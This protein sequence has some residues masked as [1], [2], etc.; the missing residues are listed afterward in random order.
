[1]MLTRH[2]SKSR[3]TKVQEWQRKGKAPFLPFVEPVGVQDEERTCV[4]NAATTS[5]LFNAVENLL[6]KVDHLKYMEFFGCREVQ[7]YQ[8]LMCTAAAV[9]FEPNTTR[10]LHWLGHVLRGPDD[11]VFKQVLLASPSATRHR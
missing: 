7:E 1:M 8:I 3:V 9:T 10:R 2:K 11:R 6:Q 5:V 4:Y